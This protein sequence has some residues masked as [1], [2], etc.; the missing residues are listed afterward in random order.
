[1]AAKRAWEIIT[2]THTTTS[3]TVTEVVVC[4]CVCVRSDRARLLNVVC[5]L[6]AAFQSFTARCRL[7]QDS[8]QC[9]HRAGNLFIEKVSVPCGQY[10]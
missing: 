1:M 8:G 2:D 5:V 3:V 6:S 9:F 7:L 10:V 4:V